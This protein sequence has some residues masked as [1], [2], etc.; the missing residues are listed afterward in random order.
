V[1]ADDSPAYLIDT[2]V[3]VHQIRDDTT[4]QLIKAKYDLLMTEITPAYCVVSEGEIRSLAYQ[5]VWGTGK[6]ESMLFLLDYYR[7]LPIETPEVLAAY[8][9]IDAYSKRA[10]IK[11][12]KNDIWIA[13]VAHVSDL[14]LLTTDEDF[15]HLDPL[16]LR[17]DLIR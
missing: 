13:A 6:L 15:D 10:G 8:A 3:L 1:I 2:N 14:H 4:G 9:V 16:F 11:M 17:R 12:G 5:W 7:R